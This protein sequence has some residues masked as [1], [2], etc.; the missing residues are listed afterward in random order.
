LSCFATCKVTVDS[1]DPKVEGRLRINNGAPVALYRE[2]GGDTITLSGLMHYRIVKARGAQG[3]WKCTT[4]GWIYELAR[5]ESPL[6]DFH[7]HPVSDSHVTTP[8]L[9]PRA[10]AVMRKWHVPSGRVLVEDVLTLAHEL[11]A[12]PAEGWE[13][14]MKRNR[15]AFLKGASWG[16]QHPG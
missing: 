7:W 2:R 12:K 5:D 16:A 3:P 14:I 4:T 6:V 11:G 15:I 9:H 13:K 10:S 8:H 1:Y